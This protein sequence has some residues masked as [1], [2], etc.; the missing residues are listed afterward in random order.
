MALGVSA[1]VFRQKVT[2]RQIAGMG[3]VV[4]GVGLLLA[5]QA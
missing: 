3:V 4:L 5:T 1:F 2:A